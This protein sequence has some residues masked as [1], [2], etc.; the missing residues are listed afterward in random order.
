MKAFFYITYLQKHYSNH[1]HSLQVHFDDYL[2]RN[3]ARTSRTQEEALKGSSSRDAPSSGPA[4][5]RG[6]SSLMLELSKGC[7]NFTTLSRLGVI[8]MAPIAMSADW[9][10]EMKGFITPVKATEY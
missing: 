7:E 1:T 9:E 8:A 4:S 5:G 3:R 2:T 10:T 6:N